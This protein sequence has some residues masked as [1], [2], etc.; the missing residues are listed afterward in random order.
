MVYALKIQKKELQ[1]YM[2]LYVFIWHVIYLWTSQTL[3]SYAIG[4]KKKN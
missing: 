1:K 3:Q 4:W 2:E